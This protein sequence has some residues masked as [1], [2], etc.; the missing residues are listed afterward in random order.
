MASVA[1]EKRSFSPVGMLD[2]V[3]TY[4]FT[5]MSILGAIGSG[6]PAIQMAAAVLLPGA[7]MGVRA[8]LRSITGTPQKP[9]GRL[10]RLYSVVAASA[11]TPLVNFPDIAQGLAQGSP[12]VA[13]TGI[14]GG[15]GMAYAATAGTSA[16]AMS[17]KSWVKDLDKD[18]DDAPAV[19]APG[20]DMESIFDLSADKSADPRA[21]KELEARPRIPF[22][23]R[24]PAPGPAAENV[25]GAATMQPKLPTPRKAPSISIATEVAAGMDKI[26]T[27]IAEPRSIPTMDALQHAMAQDILDSVFGPNSGKQ[28]EM[29]SP[30]HG[31]DP[32]A[33]RTRGP[34]WA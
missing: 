12:L 31:L 26:A 1:K 17:G 9:M 30:L 6:V 14:V 19:E 24:K 28:P 34:R 20:Q 21:M 11:M 15:L 8:T 23:M 10:T 25:V 16:K 33:E 13:V 18:L 7:H 22:A 4:A 3:G 29:D 27:G 32:R 5:G 2:Q